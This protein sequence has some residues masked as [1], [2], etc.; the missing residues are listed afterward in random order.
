MDTLNETKNRKKSLLVHFILLALCIAGVALSF[1]LIRTGI[2]SNG[3]PV[4]SRFSHYG[5][6]VLLMG[7]S[8]AAWFKTQA[9]LEARKN[10]REEITD[11]LHQ[12]TESWNRYF[13]QNRKA[14]NILLIISSSF[15]DAF[16]IFLIL[17]SIFGPTIRPFA[18]LIILIGLRQLFQVLCAL[19][20]PPGLIWHHPGIPS[21]LVTY[22]VENDFYF[23]GHTS[24]A[25]LGTIELYMINPYLGIAAGVIALFEMATVIVLR[26]HYTMDVFTA[27]LA[28]FGAVFIA[29]L[30][31]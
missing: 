15:I 29:G 7:F 2:G 28:A 25:V 1:F 27:I 21:L 11:L 12:L 19:P 26:A 13:H 18:A 5:L 30:F 22:E 3:G 10:N 24:I 17:A 8:L 16:G 9:M 20:K 31:F 6:R 14:A 23:S 4:W